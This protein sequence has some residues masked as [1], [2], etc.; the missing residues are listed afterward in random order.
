MEIWDFY[1]SGLVG[2]Q[3]HPGN[4]KEPDLE[5]AADMADAMLKVRNERCHG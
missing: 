2:W 4:Q 1:F 5:G 3:L